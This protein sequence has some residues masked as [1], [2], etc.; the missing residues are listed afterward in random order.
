[1]ENQE[2][3][4][5]GT[6]PGDERLTSAL[7]DL[8]FAVKALQLYPATS[9]V[10][11]DA[12]GRAYTGIRPLLR[13]GRLSLA[14][15]PDAIRVGE[16]DASSGNRTIKQ[17][18][19]RLHHRGVAHL[20]LDADIATDSL[21]H[22]AELLATDVETLNKDGGIAAASGRRQM[23]GIGLE[24]LRLERLFEDEEAAQ[25]DPYAEVWEQILRGYGEDEELEGL[26]WNSLAEDP[27]KLTDFMDWLLD[28]GVHSEGLSEFSRVEL[29]RT[30]CK[31]VGQAAASLGEDRV[32][33]VTEIFGRFYEKLDREAWIDLLGQPLELDAPGEDEGGGAAREAASQVAGVDLGQRIASSLSGDQI[34]DLLV[35]ALTT[36]QQASP[37][38][39][40][41]MSRLLDNRS[42]RD[43]MA[44]AI[45]DA[46]ERQ[47]SKDGKKF[48]DLWPQLTDALQQE[49]IDP[50]VSSTYRAS[51]DRLLLDD[52]PAGLWNLDKIEPRMRELDPMYLIQRK[53][54][55]LLEIL[56]QEEDDDSYQSIANELERA[57]P[58]LILHGQYIST[59]EILGVFGHHLAP[60][61][62]HSVAQR[63]AARELLVRFCNQHTL[64]EVVRNLA[65]KPRTQIDAATRIFRSLGPMAVPALIEALSQETSRSIRL[66]LVTMLAAV[67][68]QALPEIQKHLQ[69]KRWFFVRNLVWIIGEIGDARFARH[70]GMI[71]EHGD[72]RV[73]REAIRSLAKMQSPQAAGFLIDALEDRDDEIKLLAVR[74]LG[75]SGARA[76]IPQLCKLVALP[77][78]R[79]QNTEAIRAAAIALGRIGDPRVLPALKRVPQRPL[80][81]RGSRVKA[82]EAASWAIALLQGEAAGDAPEA[83]VKERSHHDSEGERDYDAP[84]SG[85]TSA[86]A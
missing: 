21:Q 24:M 11:S 23:V 19:E 22:F 32:E 1:M 60:A 71:A 56:A 14:I 15:L 53:S 26:D 76:A 41:L 30:V 43:V 83:L 27:Q 61:N 12:V 73:R 13:E 47:V 59:E 77:N 29:M 39:F 82:G 5:Q 74:G 64:R 37:R 38:I 34:E 40:G 67:G 17:L 16:L 62:N 84:D 63:Q 3:T 75:Q 2:E 68:D 25:L 51:M 85:A 7:Q 65:G 8:A 72:T 52:L 55:V 66:H 33:A 6:L 35:Y 57:L 10:V 4:T 48:E 86:V 20:H 80:L 9:P 79:G 45:R 54:K 49:N 46:V 81:F 78:R 44:Q 42:D 58:E 28:E 70:L 50:Y 18:A 36:R 31:K 69:D